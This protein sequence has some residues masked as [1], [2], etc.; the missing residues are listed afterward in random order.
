[1][2][3]LNA[4]KWPFGTHPELVSF[5]QRSSEQPIVSHLTLE[6]R[7]KEIKCQGYLAWPE[8]IAKFRN[9]IKQAQQLLWYLQNCKFAQ[10]TAKPFPQSSMSCGFHRSH[11]Q[12]VVWV[13]KKKT[14][15]NLVLSHSLTYLTELLKGLKG[16]VT[17]KNAT[18]HTDCI[19]QIVRN[20][21]RTMFSRSKAKIATFI[22]TS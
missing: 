14:W 2:V 11:L 20:K 3:S 22:I 18:I 1:M 6:E 19:I 8:V 12:P 21:I 7:K 16:K 10:R 9:Y 13:I 5:D 17:L 4:L 15:M